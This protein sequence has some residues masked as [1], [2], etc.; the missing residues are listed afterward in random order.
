MDLKYA[1]YLLGFAAVI[2]AF[3]VFAGVHNFS[4][5]GVLTSENAF[6][7]PSSF[8]TEDQNMLKTAEKDDVK[9]QSNLQG[10]YRMDNVSKAENYGL[11]FDGVDDYVDIS[12]SE[13]LNQVFGGSLNFTLSAWIK[14]KEWENH[15][16]VVHKAKNGWWSSSTAG[17]WIQ[18]DGITAVIG[19]NE[20]GNTDGSYIRV[21]DKPDLNEWHHVAA[22]ANNTHLSLFVDGNRTGTKEITDYIKANLTTN[23][24]PITI[25][26][27]TA[28]DIE[29]LNGSVSE[30]RV[31]EK[32]LSSEQVSSLYKKK[33]ISSKNLILHQTFDEADSC[34][35]TSGSRCIIDDS[36]NNYDGLPHNFQQGLNT[37]SGWTDI[38][39]YDFGKLKDSSVNGVESTVKGSA[40][41]FD[42]DDESVR[43]TE[44]ENVSFNQVTATA[45]VYLED[46]NDYRQVISKSPSGALG[47]NNF[48]FSMRNS[49]N[50]NFLYS[51]NVDNSWI[52]VSGDL[53]LNE[54]HH[55]AMTYDGSELKAYRDAE[56]IGTTSA[57]GSL[58]ENNESIRVGSIDNP[59]RDNWKGMIEDVRV[60]NTSLTDDQVKETYQFKE[61]SERPVIHYILMPFQGDIS[62]FLPLKEAYIHQNNFQSVH[63]W[64]PADSLHDLSKYLD[65]FRPY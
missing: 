48:T 1:D 41:R 17:L 58:Y 61:T 40:L 11:Q 19:S 4:D 13:D 45:W 5:L 30:I 7:Q 34:D 52:T 12:H 28:N 63:F 65:I 21:V 37:G 33:P 16:T 53:P 44:T 60:Y 9:L 23:S 42:G 50:S 10:Y 31:F 18:G 22:V 27:R 54:W 46:R 6:S 57:T 47:S 36:S 8:T 55:V 59:S 35:L 49:K 3:S 62:F 24:E 2:F 32:N 51:V 64:E 39:P 15:A 14:M 25:G 56:V 29:S 20:D 38:T 43:A 26:R